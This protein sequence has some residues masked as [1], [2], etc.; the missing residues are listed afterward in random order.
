MYD[1]LDV[2]R[3]VINYSNEKGYGVSNLKLQKLLY[4]IQAYFLVV[5]KG[6]PCSDDTICFPQII[7][8]WDFG[9][10]VPKAYHEFKIFGASN[11]PYISNYITV[12]NR[13]GDIRFNKVLFSDNCIK[14]DDRK[15][16]NDV[17]DTFKDYSAA[18]LVEL[19]HK[20][21]PWKD[22]YKRGRN[23]EITP[24]SIWSYFYNE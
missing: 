22:A 20:Q 17:I 13:N 14:I 18:T 8:A 10:V 16:I 7:E 4:F 6:R 19:T 1:V 5:K 21:R 9:P 11:I 24:V 15:I 23:S 2:S 3:Y 12:E